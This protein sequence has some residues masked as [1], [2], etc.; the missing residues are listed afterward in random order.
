M[1]NALYKSVALHLVVL[2]LFLVDVPVFWRR[3]MT[4]EQ[5]PI[6]VDLNNVK[7]SEMTNLPPKAKR[8][9]EEKQASK[10]KRKIEKNYTKDEPDQTA[11]SEERAAERRGRNAA[12]Q[13][14]TR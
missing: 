6:I 8:G 1:K 7:I 12:G 10:I 13:A 14:G 4:I 3:N 11:G 2:I 5:V 9:P